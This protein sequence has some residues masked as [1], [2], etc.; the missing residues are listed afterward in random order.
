MI[1]IMMI[2]IMW[3][4]KVTVIPVFVG[5]PGAFSRTRKRNSMN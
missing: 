1:I 2:I 4:M 5:Y 3:K